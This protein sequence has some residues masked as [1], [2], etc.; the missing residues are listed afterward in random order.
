MG[1]WK[2]NTFGYTK[3]TNLQNKRK[4]GDIQTFMIKK[5]NDIQQSKLCGFVV[6]K[7]NKINF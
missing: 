6:E 5:L 4:Y 2:G 3:L 7:H 1:D